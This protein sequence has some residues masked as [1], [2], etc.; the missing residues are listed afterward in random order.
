MLLKDL[1]VRYIDFIRNLG[2]EQSE[3][4]AFSVMNELFHS[5]VKKIENGATI[6][7]SLSALSEQLRAVR[8]AVF[9]WTTTALQESDITLDEGKKSAVV[10]FAWEATGIGQHLTAVRLEFKDDKINRI[11]EVFNKKSQQEQSLLQK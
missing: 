3:D 4:K 1:A 6:V 8:K 2:F 11:T 7:D 5:D 9:P 10:F